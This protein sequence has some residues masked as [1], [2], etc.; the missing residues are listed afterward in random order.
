MSRQG[1]NKRDAEA[2]VLLFRHVNLLGSEYRL[3]LRSCGSAAVEGDCP[4][5][6]PFRRTGR[7]Y[8]FPPR[9]PVEPDGQKTPRQI[10]GN[11]GV[12]FG[13]VCR[14]WSSGPGSDRISSFFS[15]KTGNLHGFEGIFGDMRGVSGDLKNCGKRRFFSNRAGFQAEKAGIGAFPRPGR[16]VRHIR[17][18][19]SVPI[20]R[21]GVA[22]R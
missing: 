3:R 7:K 18:P 17:L 9:P 1:R 4:H 22:R 10:T 16:I 19:F 12:S 11:A 21:P 14:R 5:D 2:P 15:G 13:L 6:C 20:I 8:P